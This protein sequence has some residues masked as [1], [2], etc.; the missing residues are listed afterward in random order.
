MLMRSEVHCVNIKPL[1]IDSDFTHR[2][3]HVGMK[4]NIDNNFKVS[5][6]EACSMTLIAILIITRRENTHY[7]SQ[8][9]SLPCRHW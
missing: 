3:Y 6:I 8:D 9:S 7:S 1:Q 4:N 2:L 5:R